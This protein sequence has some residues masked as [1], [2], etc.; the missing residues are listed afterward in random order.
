MPLRGIRGAIDLASN[1][2]KEVLGRTRELLEAMV[3]ANR[4]RPAKIACAIFTMTPDLN[5][6]FPAYAARDLGWQIVP[7]IC[8][9][10]I[11][12]PGGMKRVVRVLLLVDSAMPPGKVKHQYLGRTASLRPDL[13]A[14]SKGRARR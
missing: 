7:M 3:R 14:T 13:A 12:V 6:D 11:G 5:A 2:R 10:E 4:L 9:V 1:T 8:S